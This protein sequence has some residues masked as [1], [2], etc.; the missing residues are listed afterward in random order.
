[1][2]EMFTTMPSDQAVKAEEVWQALQVD[3][4]GLSSKSRALEAEKSGHRIQMDQP[5]IVVEAIREMV[6]CLR[7]N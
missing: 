7:T 5:E 3:L 2:P 6:D 1:M 4:A